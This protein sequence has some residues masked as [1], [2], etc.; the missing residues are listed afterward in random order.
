MMK[1]SNNLI[2]L[3]AI[4]FLLFL[5]AKAQIPV[6]VFAGDKKVT[7]DVMFFKYVKHTNGQPSNWLFFNRNRASIDYKMTE[8]TNLPQFGSTEAISYNHKKLRGFAPVVV[9]QLLNRGVYP[10]AGIQFA[11]IRNNL[12]I[13]TWVVYE[14]V[15]APN[16]DYFFLG[17]YTPKITEK[18]N[19]FTQVELV[20]AFP[21]VKNNAYSFIQR[22]RL[23]LKVKE[24]QF[25]TGIDLT[26]IGRNNL[27]KT[28]NVGAYLRY[29]F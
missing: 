6:E 21:I 26:A 15:A 3:V 12:T 27:V 5:K 22:F 8:T 4:T 20:N 1:C 25:G 10:K 29:E 24:L 7:L 17:R 9:A 13:F 28:K 11:H 14:T 2:A 19:L 18:L 23:G 16:L